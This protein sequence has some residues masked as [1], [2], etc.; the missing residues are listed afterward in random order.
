MTVVTISRELGCEGTRIAEAVAVELG[1]HCV[2]K[3]VLAEMARLAGVSVQAVVDAEERLLS[4][5]AVVSDEMRAF[6]K[7]SQAPGGFSEERYIEQMTAAIRAMADQGDVVF[8]GRGAQMILAGRAG[9]LHVHLYAP[10]DVRAAR[11]AQRRGL[12][13]AGAA[14]RLIQQ[15]DEQ[16]RDWYRRFFNRANWK[17]PRYYHLMINTGHIPAERAVEIIVRAV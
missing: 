3:E 1:A 5:P 10:E 14:L 17:D 12:T 16:R 15:S 4:R 8:V 2:D 6:F 9:T 7:R 13:D 11:I